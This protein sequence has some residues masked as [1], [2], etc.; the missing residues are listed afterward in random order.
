MKTHQRSNNAVSAEQVKILNF[1]ISTRDR[2]DKKISQFEK[3][4][5]KL[6]SKSQG[7]K[8]SSRK[9]YVKRM[10]ND[11]TLSEALQKVLSRT[12]TKSPKEL[13][14]ELLEKGL[15]K[16]KSKG[17]PTSISLCLNKL[18]EA[19]AVIKEGHG[20]F[21]ATPSGTIYHGRK[22]GRP[23]KQEQKE[24]QEMSN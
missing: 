3:I 4:S 13:S 18:A 17:F 15:Y 21:K 7:S 23:S 9:R 2:I 14:E 10:D 6:T 1:L 19:G 20:S 5:T 22:R 8:T 12:K 11:L 16:T 24:Y